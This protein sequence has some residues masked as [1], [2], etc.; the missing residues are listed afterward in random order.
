M[1]P[2]LEKSFPLVCTACRVKFIDI[3][4]TLQFDQ[5]SRLAFCLNLFIFLANYFETNLK[6]V[7]SFPL[8]C[9]VHQEESI[10]I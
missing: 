4:N 10:D 7:R 2:K 3:A 8:V 5:Y 9:R 1:L 6:L